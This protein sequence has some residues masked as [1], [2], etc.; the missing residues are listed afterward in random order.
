MRFCLNALLKSQDHVGGEQGERA[1]MTDVG[2]L[3]G[4]EPATSGQGEPDSLG[5][6][7]SDIL[8]RL[9]IALWF[10]AQA[11]NFFRAIAGIVSQ[12]GLLGLDALGVTQ[13]GV[14]LCIFFFFTMMATLTLVRMRPVAKAAGWQPRVTALLGTYLLYLLPFLP[15]QENLGIPLHLL[16]ATLIITGNV[17]ALII[18]LH[19]GRSFSINAEA[20]RLV[21]GGPYAIVRHPLYL[22]E[23]IALLGVFIEF[24]SISAAV[25]MVAQLT[26]QF[27]RMRNEEAVL[28]RSFPDY[29]P[30]MARTA[31]FIPGFW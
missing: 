6:R 8:V 26:F 14:K 5:S 10:L 24:F 18:L 11:V 17:L 9:A 31:R 23:Q 20:R 15:A 12:S 16:S 1:M 2:S 21:T 27:Q 29:G 30:Y 22:A 7:V 28:L 3:R 25:L 4:D 13:I 19:L